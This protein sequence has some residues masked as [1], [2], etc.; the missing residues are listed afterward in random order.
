MN[1]DDLRALLNDFFEIATDAPATGEPVR[2]ELDT[3]TFQLEPTDLEVMVKVHLC[4]LA[5]GVDEA[6]LAG[7]LKALVRKRL[8]YRPTSEDGF[9]VFECALFVEGLSAPDVAQQF[10]DLFTFAKHPAVQAVIGTHQA[11]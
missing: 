11:Y 9:L 1:Q 6:K 5:P 7:D 10:R 3:A 2:F 4:E 8:S